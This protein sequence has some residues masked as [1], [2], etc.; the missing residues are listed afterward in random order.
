M[1]GNKKK[2][3]KSQQR[4]QREQGHTAPKK[5]F[6]NSAD[7]TESTVA[8]HYHPIL[9]YGLTVLLVMLG[10]YG[11]YWSESLV[12][13]RWF[14]PILEAQTEMTR[15]LLLVLQQEV[16]RNGNVLVSATD[17]LRPFTLA[18]G[19][20]CEAFDV[21]ILAMVGILCF[22]SVWRVR[23][24][25]AL[26]VGSLI[27]GINVLRL[28]SLF[29]VGLYGPEY[30]DFV[31]YNLWQVVLVLCVIGAWWLWLTRIMPYINSKRTV[32]SDWSN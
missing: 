30:F 19:L 10:F 17:K 25:G 29:L 15:W 4:R 12:E 3:N 23:L 11:L 18:V 20:G 21:T 2:R 22:P 24:I 7:E 9:R 14:R 31:H 32:H 13:R 5:A 8:T 26:F 16:E 6:E 27:Q 28:T 1:A